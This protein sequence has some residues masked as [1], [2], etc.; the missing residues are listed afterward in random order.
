MV[1]KRFFFICAGIL[2]LAFA[3]HLGA[4]SASGEAYPTGPVECVG[5]SE[6]TAAAVINHELWRAEAGALDGTGT[7]PS[8]SRAVA[9]G[10]DGVVLENGEAWKWNGVSWGLQ[11]TFPFSGP[12][13]ATQETWGSLKARYRPTA[14]TQNK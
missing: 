7:I 3:Y 6:H 8:A 9:C 4:R 1:A 5:Y 2:C 11:G 14:P 12:T 13:P 10:Y